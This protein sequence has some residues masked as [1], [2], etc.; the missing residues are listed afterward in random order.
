MHAARTEPETADV[1][2]DDVGNAPSNTAHRTS[3]Q[4][5][6]QLEM[7]DNPA[8]IWALEDDW[9]ALF[10]ACPDGSYF[11]S[12]DYL[13]AAWECVA[14]ARGRILNIIVGRYFGRVVIIWPLVSFS[15]H[16]ARWLGS[17]KT[18]YRDVLVLPSPE[19]DSQVLA[20]WKFIQSECGFDWIFLQDIKKDSTIDRVL[21]KHAPPSQKISAPSRILDC[22]AWESWDDFLASR[23]RK[24]RADQR[25]QCQRLEKLG[26][27]TFRIINSDDAIEP[28]IK[29]MIDRK[30]EWFDRVELDERSFRSQEY[31]KFIAT[32][33]R[34]A[35]QSNNL[36]LATLCV[37][38]NIVAVV[39][40]IV[41]HSEMTFICFAYDFEYEKYSP[42]RLAMTKM[43]EWAFEN[44]MSSIDFMPSTPEYK[45]DW[46]ND[47]FEVFDWYIPC[48]GRGWLITR[49][50]NSRSRKHLVD[51]HAKLVALITP[52]LFPLTIR[53]AVRR[54]LLISD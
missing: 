54:V 2:V 3:D 45:Y 53:E 39:Y 35:H 26:S 25:R 15:K 42:G 51:L 32:A 29:W 41:F 50:L 34:H 31:R 30:V 16:Q 14:S 1:A 47:E 12:F 22:G 36:F 19:S 10:N 52:G 43:L 8:D 17:E 23:R 49:W 6:L 5:G 18:E 33:A 28:T 27:V 44:K 21:A 13:S 37:D 48:S 38:E 46:T 24:L 4:V 40:A 20:T 9:R 11:Q 7:I